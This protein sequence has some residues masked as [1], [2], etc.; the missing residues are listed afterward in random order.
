MSDV[1]DP[2]YCPPGHVRP[3]GNQPAPAEQDQSDTEESSESSEEEMDIVSNRMSRKGSYWAELPPTQAKT[4][5]HNLLRSRSG[6]APGFST[7]SPIDAWK[8]FITDS[9]L[10]EVLRCTNMEGRRVATNRGKEWKNLSKEELMAFIGLTILAGSEK[11]WDVPIRVLFGS[12]LHN[13]MYKATMSIGRFEDIRRLLRFDDKRTRASRLETDHMTAFRYI[14]DLFL[15]CRQKFIPSDCVTVDEQLVPFRGRT[16]FLQYMPSKP[17]KYGI[18]IFW[19]CDARTP[20]A[21]DGIVYTGRQPGEEV[22]KNLGENTVRQLCSGFRHTGR[23]ITTDNFFTSVPLAEHLLEKGLT[24]VGT[25][26]QN[27]PDIPPVM[28]ASKSREVHSTE[29]GFNGSMT[30]I[31]Y[32]R[33]KGKAVLSTMH[34]SKMVD[35]NSQ[36]KKTE[37]ILF[38]NQTKGGVDTVDQMVGYYTCTPGPWC[39][40][41]T[42]ARRHFLTELSKE[43]VTPHMKSRLEGTPNLPTYITEAMGRC[44]VTKAANQ[45]QERSTEGQQKRKRCQMCPRNKDRKATNCCWKCST[46]VCNG[47]SQKQIVCDNCTQ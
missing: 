9:I 29:F 39:W 4:P 35:E 21:I 46:P 36:K 23:N 22:Q 14:W 38:Y 37:I 30:M 12:P 40:G 26:R 31:S 5:S 45:Q 41:I 8:L 34:H 44:G 24:I 1:E 47:H 10:E 25:M 3:S 27:K 28:K 16:M 15:V 11:N 7:V 6:P 43:L 20:Y 42:N 17:A 2:D 13:P 32:I 18:K 19:V 33:K